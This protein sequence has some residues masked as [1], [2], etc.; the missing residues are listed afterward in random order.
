MGRRRDPALLWLLACLVVRDAHRS[1]A[2]APIARL[3]R[4]APAPQ[5]SDSDVPKMTADYEISPASFAGVDDLDSI[6]AERA[7]TLMKAAGIASAA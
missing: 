4:E 2:A 6:D 1:T 5:R 3:R 7:R